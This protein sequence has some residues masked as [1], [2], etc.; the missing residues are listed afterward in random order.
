[1][2]K[3]CLKSLQEDAADDINRR[4]FQMQ[5]FNGILRVKTEKKKK[6]DRYEDPFDH[7]HTRVCS[8]SKIVF[9]VVTSQYKVT[10]DPF[11]LQQ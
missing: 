3:A 2:Q 10:A 6:I 9:S 1:M 8:P 4:H 5:V 7:I 11:L